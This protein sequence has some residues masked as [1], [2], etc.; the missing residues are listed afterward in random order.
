MGILN[1]NYRVMVSS[2]NGELIYSIH[3]VSYDEDFTP[4]SYTAN[5]VKVL[6]EEIEGLDWQLNMMKECLKKPIIWADD[7]FPQVYQQSVTPEQLLELIKSLPDS[8]SHIHMF[9]GECYVTNEWFAG[10]F[11]GRGFTGESYEEA[12]Q[13]LL[14]YMY[15]HIGHDS[16]VGKAITES[17][18][19]DLEKLYKYC[20]HESI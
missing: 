8:K 12:A 4:V 6:S 10:N 19:P 11:A 18:F 5:P 17:G 14:N 15:N 20:L 7:K 3:E 9:Q 1:W 2:D 16:I 13:K